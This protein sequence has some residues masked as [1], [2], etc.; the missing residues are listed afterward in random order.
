MTVEPRAPGDEAQSGVTAR[1]TPVRKRGEECFPTYEGNLFAK[2]DQVRKADGTLSS[3][4]DKD[5][6]NPDLPVKLSDAIRGQSTWML[7]SE[8]DEAFWGWLLEHNY[9]FTDFLVLLDSR[10]REHRFRDAGLTN[11]PGMKAQKDPKKKILGLYLDQSAGEYGLPK[12]YAH[13]KCALFEP[14][15]EA[16]Y[17][18]ALAA[19]ATDGADPNVYGYPS[20]VIG[21]RLYPNPDFFAQNDE[22]A[23]QARAYWKT[24]VED[25]PEDDYYKLESLIA[26]DPNLVRPFRISM[27]CAFCHI[28]P[29]PLN[30]PKDPE[31]PKWENLS[32]TVGAQ[33]WNGSKAFSNL[34][35]PKSFFFQL[36]Q[37][38]QPGTLDT[39]LLSTDQINNPNTMN[40][41]WDIPARIDRAKLNPPE[42]QSEA[43]LLLPGIE[44]PAA[45]PRLVP[46]IL[47]DGSDSVGISGA[48]SR[49]YL[50]VGAYYE[51]WIRLHNPIIGFRAQRP[52]EMTTIREKSAY[53][54]MT[55]KYRVPEIAAFLTYENKD[56]ENVTEPMKLARVPGVQIKPSEAADAAKGRAV[57]LENCAICHS[58]KQPRDF[59]LEFSRDWRTK[60]VPGALVLPM[61]F[62]DWE[63]FKRT[64]AYSQYVK[65]IKSE[66]GDATATP[67][68]FLERN[69]LSTD[70]RIP[71]TLV[72]TNSARAVATNAMKGQVWENFSSD[73]YKSLP[74]VGAVHFYNPYLHEPVDEWGNNDMYYPPPGGPGYYRPASLVS[75]WATA[76]FLHNN[77]LG[78]YTR[79]PSVRVSVKGRLE[80]F[81]DAVEKLFWKAKRVPGGEKRDHPGD[82]RAT[83]KELAEQDPG[84]IYRTTT[85]SWIDF[86]ATFIR[87]LLVGVMGQ[88]LVSILTRYLWYMF[89][90]VAILFAL[91]GRQ[92]HA[93]FT[94]MFIAVLAGVVLCLTRIDKIYP[95]LWWMPVGAVALALLLWLGPQSRA[96]TA[97]FFSLLAAAFL[98]VTAVAGAWVDGSLG[99][100][101]LGPIPQGTPVNLIMNLNPQAPPRDL[102]DALS[103]LTRGILSVRKNDLPDED[104]K[105]LKA[106]EAEAGLPLLKVSK[107]P[108]FVLD[109]GHWFAEGLSDEQKQQ[110]KEFLKTL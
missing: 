76:P 86:P 89:A 105:A 17:A 70:I 46:R 80:A 44:A 39:S 25:Q 72:G 49:V 101:K 59:R 68:R 27:T 12:D 38:W 45:N 57:F 29:H 65:L 69:Y 104:G 92:Q 94:L 24:H 97:A 36:I 5:K 62:A 1:G 3:V 100:V 14:T 48:L 31:D 106:F 42:K 50:N 28:A 63:E 22:K 37:S 82:L 41:I 18:A 4:F 58:S 15:P 6:E 52:F 90:G 83:H 55:E 20:G 99:G 107:C 77:A 8:G 9:G 11:Q 54:R 43:N 2:V 93:G 81:D 108:D 51:Q 103:G 33:Y 67:D 84:F 23:T 60:Q 10:E 47:I 109:R 98:L 7:W 79:D 88:R 95:S 30:P 85:R 75:V 110:L 53:W 26:A 21:L 13:D 66:A 61:D 32:S 74:A 34:K 87:P 19:L 35:G 73:A 91:F 64:D 40:A 71:V 102:L 56:G 78:L 16:R 96:I